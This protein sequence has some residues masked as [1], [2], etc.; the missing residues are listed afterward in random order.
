MLRSWMRSGVGS[1][2]W[3]RPSNGPATRR[4]A[5]RE[6]CRSDAPNSGCG[7]IG[8]TNASVIIGLP[9]ADRRIVLRRPIEQA[10]ERPFDAAAGL[11]VKPDE[12]H[13]KRVVTRDV[14]CFAGDDRPAFTG[15]VDLQ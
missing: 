9:T 12:P 8:G 6:I 3:R 14:A 11:L 1:G 7:R 13:G 5:R 4:S 10:I 15:Q 2:P